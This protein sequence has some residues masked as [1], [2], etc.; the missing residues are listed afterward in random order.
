MKVFQDLACP[1]HYKITMRHPLLLKSLKGLLKHWASPITSIVPGDLSLQEKQKEPTN[2]TIGNKKGNQRDLPQMEGGFTS[3]PPP[4]S[5]CSER[6]LVL[7]FMR[8]YMGDLLF[9]SVIYF[10]IQRLKPFDLTLWP[11]GN[12]NKKCICG[13]STRTQ[14]ILRDGLC[15]RDSSTN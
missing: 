11:L 2:L 6:M 10:Y 15:P 13:V 14:R 1:G 4:H 7:A 3:S 5:H 12:S 9:K 8:C